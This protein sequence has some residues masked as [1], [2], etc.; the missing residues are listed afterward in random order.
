[1]NIIEQFPQE[2]QTV[3]M[4]MQAPVIEVGF[5]PSLEIRGAARPW[6]SRKIVELQ[7]LIQMGQVSLSYLIP[8][9]VKQ[10]AKRRS[11]PSMVKVAPFVGQYQ[12]EMTT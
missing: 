11:R 7:N 10:M 8:V 2:I 5:G 3:D 4:M 9:V 12:Q 1:V 6:V